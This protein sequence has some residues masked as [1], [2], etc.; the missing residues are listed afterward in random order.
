M[1][2]QAAIEQV[3][4]DRSHG[5]LDRI[6]IRGGVI[7]GGGEVSCVGEPVRI[8]GDQL[9]SEPDKGYAQHL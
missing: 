9:R 3:R 8:H 4:A 2:V 1:V 6:Q 7:C 5:V